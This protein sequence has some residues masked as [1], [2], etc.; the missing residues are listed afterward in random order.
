MEMMNVSDDE[1]NNQEERMEE[2]VPAAVGLP[3]INPAEL[4]TVG[5]SRSGAGDE[6]LIDVDWITRNLISVFETTFYGGDPVDW[7]EA[8]E[9]LKSYLSWAVPFSYK[10]KRDVSPLDKTQPQD[11]S[12]A[13]ADLYLFP[14]LLG[15]LD[16]NKE[17]TNYFKVNYIQIHIHVF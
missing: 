15:F 4:D 1:S 14:V 3:N 11:G 12:S 5:S 17:L 2:E 8:E 10:L 6:K 13:R 7:T 9:V 16:R